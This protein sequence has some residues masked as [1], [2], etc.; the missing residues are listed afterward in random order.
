MKYKE[1]FGNSIE[2]D[3][4]EIKKEIDVDPSIVF[5]YSGTGTLYDY[6]NALYNDG[7]GLDSNYLYKFKV[8]Y[9]RKNLKISYSARDGKRNIKINSMSN[10][11][12]ELDGKSSCKIVVENNDRVQLAFIVQQLIFIEYPLEKVDVLLRKE[13]KD[14]D[15]TKR[16]MKNVDELLKDCES[17]ITRLNALRRKVEKEMDNNNPTKA[18]RLKDIDET[19]SSCNR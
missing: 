5:V 19:L 18:D 2:E 3:I 15:K 9:E 12:N 17:S 1:L 6:I 11:V 7:Q 16:F 13:E 8:C 14:A 10:L 4:D